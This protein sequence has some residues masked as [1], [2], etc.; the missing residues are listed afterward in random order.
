M[1]VMNV[2]K[3]EF[4][5]I[6]HIRWGLKLKSG[7]DQILVVLRIATIWSSDGTVLADTY[8]VTGNVR[9]GAWNMSVGMGNVMF[10]NVDFLQLCF[11]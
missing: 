7:N 9:L 3:Y 2:S 5:W 10:R 4:M 1:D 6:T 11:K 8:Y